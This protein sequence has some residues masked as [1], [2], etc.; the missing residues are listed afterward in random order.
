LDFNLGFVGGLEF[1]FEEEEGLFI[2]IEG[3][4]SWGL[5]GYC[6]L[7]DLFCLAE[8]DVLAELLESLPIFLIFDLF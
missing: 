3:E 8:G 1:G 2:G 6:G 4:F 7:T 5:G